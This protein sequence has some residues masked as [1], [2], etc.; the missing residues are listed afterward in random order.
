LLRRGSRIARAHADNW[1][2]HRV[3]SRPYRQ[4]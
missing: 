2:R 4:P 3:H 1:R